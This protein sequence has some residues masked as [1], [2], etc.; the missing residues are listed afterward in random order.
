M[1]RKPFIIWLIENFS[2]IFPLIKTARISYNVFI[3]FIIIRMFLWAILC[4]CEE[5]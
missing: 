5:D 1:E 4:V 3:M 2:I